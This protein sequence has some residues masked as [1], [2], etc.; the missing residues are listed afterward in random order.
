[1]ARQLVLEL[2]L[3]PRFGREDFM[4]APSNEAAYALIE[5]GRTGRPASFISA[6]RGAAAKATW[7]RSG[8][9]ALGLGR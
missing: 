1:M 4:V 7:P 9:G 6:A 2:E 3:A 8:R 5:A